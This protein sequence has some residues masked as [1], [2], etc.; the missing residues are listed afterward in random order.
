MKLI[1]ITDENKYEIISELKKIKHKIINLSA[2]ELDIEIP[3]IKQYLFKYKQLKE[4]FEK[5]VKDYHKIIKSKTF[6]NLFR[7]YRDF[8]FSFP[9]T[10]DF[11]A[12]VHCHLQDFEYSLDTMNCINNIPEIQ[13]DLE[14]L[15]TNPL[16][17]YYPKFYLEQIKKENPN[18]IVGAE[19]YYFIQDLENLFCYSYDFIIFKNIDDNQYNILD[20]ADVLKLVTYNILTYL[21]CAILHKVQNCEK[22][23]DTKKEI[24]SSCF[25]KRLKKEH[26]DILKLRKDLSP[27]NS[28]KE[29]LK[30][31]NCNYSESAIKA[32]A[33]KIND[34]LGSNNIDEA[35]RI[36]EN[37]YGQL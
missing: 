18:A 8:L 9:D 20:S 13:E 17:S 21:E 32:M 26:L 6:K 7:E 2:Q 29:I 31:M 36:F 15:Y 24:N 5:Q 28:Y 22:D 27:D 11:H 23:E 37:Q 1:E 14:I 16:I 4:E 19:T 34:I 12:I 10:D 33:N 3:L 30:Q 35:I 25:P